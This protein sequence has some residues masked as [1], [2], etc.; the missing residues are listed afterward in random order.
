MTLSRKLRLLVL[1]L[2]LGCTV[3]CDQTLKHV[4]RMELSPFN[5]VMLPG[6]FGELTLVE[7]PG[8]FLSF[9][10]SLSPSVRALFFTLGVGAGLLVLFAWLVGRTRLDGLTFVGLGMVMAG[11]TS[12]L[13]DRVA[14]QGFVT[15]FITLRIGPFQ[16]GVFNVADAIVMLGLVL[17]AW[18]HWKQRPHNPPKLSGPTA[19]P[20]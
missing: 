14:R 5:S 20:S 10:A 12:N 15:D 6:G 11:G 13:I 16:T 18:A 7:N 8:V 17:V 1:I 9:G 2:V 19:P 4:A 3:G